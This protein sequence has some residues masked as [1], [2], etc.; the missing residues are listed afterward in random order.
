[1]TKNPEKREPRCIV[2][3]AASAQGRFASTRQG[4]EDREVFLYQFS[5]SASASAC[6]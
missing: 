6:A 2:A 5:L 4:R 3:L 1:M